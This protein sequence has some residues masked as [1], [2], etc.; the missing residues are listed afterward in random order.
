MKK[1]VCGGGKKNAA[2]CYQVKTGHMKM[3]H[4]RSIDVLSHT[5]RHA[6]HTKAVLV[7]EHCT[8]ALQ[9]CFKPCS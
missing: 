8:I 3:L 6:L 9:I 5:F 4:A 2:Y 1:T 7:Y